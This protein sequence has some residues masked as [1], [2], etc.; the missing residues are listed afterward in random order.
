MFQVPSRIGH[1]VA[2]H[3]QSA[4]SWKC[5]RSPAWNVIQM[6]DWCFSNMNT[7]WAAASTAARLKNPTLFREKAY[8]DGQWLESK[9]SNKYG[10]AVFIPEVIAPHAVVFTLHP[11][12]VGSQV[13]RRADDIFGDGLISFRNPGSLRL[14]ADGSGGGFGRHHK[15]NDV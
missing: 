1:A 6:Q 3:R 15:G 9:S 8:I 10:F 7:R 14:H 12:S 11:V 13:E 4:A 2:G 5:A